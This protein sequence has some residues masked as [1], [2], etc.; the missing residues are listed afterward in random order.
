MEVDEGEVA[1]GWMLRVKSSYIGAPELWFVLDQ[2]S[3]P[4][5]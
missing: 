2:T 4:A 5:I 1:D 3:Y